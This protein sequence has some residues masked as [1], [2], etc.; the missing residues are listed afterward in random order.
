MYHEDLID[1]LP[2]VI[3]ETGIINIGGKS[4]SV[5]DFAKKHNKFVKSLR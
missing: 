3:H 5:Y 2:K 1:M 4:Q